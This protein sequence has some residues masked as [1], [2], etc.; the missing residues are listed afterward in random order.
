M[1]PAPFTWRIPPSPCITC[2]QGRCY[3]TSLGS[4]NGTFLNE[5]KV[6]RK[7]RLRQGMVLRFGNTQAVF[8]E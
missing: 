4:T 7:M 2:D 5:K 8:H 3:F 6:I 1:S